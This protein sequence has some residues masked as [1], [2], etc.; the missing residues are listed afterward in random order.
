[1]SE[2]VNSLI[3]GL[4]L[5][6]NFAKEIGRG[7]LSSQFEKL[8]E[9]DVLGESLIEMKESLQEAKKEE[10]KRKIE[11][12][13][14]N[15]ATQGLAK[16]SDILRESA[17][18]LED[19]SYSI[20]SN[21]VKY[22]D[23]NQG[24]LF[25]INEDD[26]KEKYIELI[27]C[28]AY[29]RRKYVEKKIAFGEGLVG[30][31]VLEKETIHM[32]DVPEDYINI[33]SGLGKDC[34]RSLLIVPLILNEEVYGVIEM[35]SFKEFEPHVVSF[36]E[37]IGQSIA[38]TISN[39][40][41][42]L[43]TAQLLEESRIQAEEL[44]AQE[45]EMRQNL[46]ELQATQEE[47]ARK[48]AEMSGMLAAMNASLLVMECD[49]DGKIISINNNFSRIIE[50]QKDEIIGKLYKNTAVSIGMNSE[51]IDKVWKSLLEGEIVKNIVQLDVNENEVWINQTYAPIVNNEGK[52]YKVLNIGIDITESK[53]QEKQV[54][55]L[56]EES[57]EQNKELQ[58]LKEEDERKTKEMLETVEAHRK[59]LK[60]IIDQIPGKVF[61][62][63]KDG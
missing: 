52:P 32:T 15:W 29:E 30:R 16:F 28:Y 37:K 20:L 51:K 63:D 10:E 18:N 38:S 48:E 45:E 21:L 40:K 39:V 43:R 41:I 19:L 7:N 53:N 55:R 61:L 22:I 8:S 9:N 27:G 44:A 4:N 49:I 58:R 54:Q 34:P 50:Q 42:N 24:G 46:E 59:T 6:A 14:Q 3:D 13:K 47:S 31:C 1:M 35:A 62:K 23:A 60:E 12:A 36:V 56:L 26:N 25:I 11:D 33:T 5:T 2:S 57:Q 17:E